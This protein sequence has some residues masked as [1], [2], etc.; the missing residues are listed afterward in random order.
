LDRGERLGQIGLREQ[1]PTAFRG[2]HAEKFPARRGRTRPQ[3]TLEAEVRERVF[4]HA[5]LAH[6]DAPV[7]LLACVPGGKIVADVE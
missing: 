4:V 1:P 7:D 5:E 2:D 3:R 6:G